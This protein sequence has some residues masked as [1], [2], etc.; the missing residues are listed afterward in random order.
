MPCRDLEP[1]TQLYVSVDA[2]TRDS[3]KAI[4][5]PLF[6]DFW[7]RF[8]ECLRL[9]RD[10]HQR[11]VY[12]LPAHPPPRDSPCMSKLLQTLAR[13]HNRGDARQQD[14][15]EKC[16]DQPPQSLRVGVL[17]LHVPGQQQDSVAFVRGGPWTG[18]SDSVNSDVAIDG[19]TD[20]LCSG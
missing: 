10:K 11:T 5:R 3:L 4:D 17:P 18:L 12:R 6:K 15:A 19:L 16:T 7:E 20:A 1:I 9:L 2:A 14:I 8:L 13:V